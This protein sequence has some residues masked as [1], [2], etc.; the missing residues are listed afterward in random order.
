VKS[1]TN[2]SAKPLALCNSTDR[3][4]LVLH[5]QP[6]AQSKRPGVLLVHAGRQAGELSSVLRTLLQQRHCLVVLHT[7]FQLDPFEPLATADD[8][9]DGTEQ[10]QLG[11]IHAGEPNA[12][13]V[14][15]MYI[16][17]VITHM[18][19]CLPVHAVPTGM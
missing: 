18:C 11:N 17:C 2:P 7:E 10:L 3:F 15:C 12:A 5:A 1:D 8:L 6:A 14:H 4:V 13:A 19:R 9:S 16:A